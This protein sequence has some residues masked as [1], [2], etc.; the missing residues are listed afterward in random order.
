M[1]KTILVAIF[2][3]L[4][5]SNVSKASIKSFLN[6]NATENFTSDKSADGDSKI[7]IQNKSQ[8]Q[9]YLGKKKIVLEDSKDDLKPTIICNDI[10]FGNN[11]SKIV[12]IEYFSP[13]CTFCANYHKHVFPLIKK[14]F[15]DTGII[16]YII[17]EFI[18]NKQDL[19]AMV[20]ARCIGNQDTYTKLIDI[21]LDSQHKWMYSKDYRKMLTEIGEKQGVSSKQYTICLNN[22]S[23][24]ENLL[25]NT[26]VILKDSCFAGVPAL[27]I[28]G[29][30]FVRPYTLYE[31]S[32][33]INNLISSDER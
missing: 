8:H 9:E 12:L 4:L 26:K 30:Q 29:K 32:K 3:V 14:K 2:T 16:Q 17:R 24:I 19:D 25:E 18:G 11:K 6:E 1:L 28:N 10:K 27:F 23:K 22:Q 15:I 13:T 31:L 21:I 5:L 7:L 20:L 33:A